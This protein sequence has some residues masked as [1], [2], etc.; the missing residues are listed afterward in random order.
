M[1][2]T[3]EAMT[4]S[5]LTERERCILALV[6]QAYVAEASP[7][8]SRS[9][10]RRFGLRLSPATIRNTM[11]D[12]EAAGLLEQ[13]HTSAGRVPTDKGY[14]VYVDELMS[15]IVLSRKEQAAIREAVLGDTYGRAWEAAAILDQTVKALSDL[16]SLLA[17]SLEPSLEEG[18][19]EKLELVSLGDRK[20]LAVLTIKGGF[21]RTVVM[22]L[23]AQVERGALDETAQL[24]NERLSGLPMRII[25]QSARERMRDAVSADPK[26]LKL[27][28]NY[29]EDLFAPASAEAQIHYSGTPNILCLP[30]FADRERMVSLIGALEEKDI[31]IRILGRKSGDEG[32]T[33]T[34]GEENPEGEIHFCS[35]VASPYT[36]GDVA[37][38]VGVVG[39]TRMQYS[40][41]VSVVDYTARLVSEVLG[42]E[43]LI[44]EE[45]GLRSG[46]GEPQTQ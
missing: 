42:S 40:K 29:T 35:I 34:I 45:E 17:V 3:D 7:V 32:L 2:H 10:A 26:V 1:P 20:L 8:G 38:S 13:P 19:F 33:I 22:E 24:L 41:L 30:E 39:P 21:L 9:L 5:T 23:E 4:E 14:R 37:G 11:N 15:P 25:R 18:T 16:T 27:I 12:L 43:L 46:S 36:V 28:L 44:G 31:F 6:I